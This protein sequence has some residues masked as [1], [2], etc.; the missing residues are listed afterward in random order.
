MI[1]MTFR[2]I[3]LFILLKYFILYII[4]MIKMIDYR[5][6]RVNEL[7]NAGDLFYYS[8]LILFLPMVSMILFSAPIYYSFKLKNIFSFSV[9]ILSI[10][11][12]EYFV[13]VYLTSDKH[14]DMNGIVNG[15]ISLLLFILFFYRHINS[16]FKQSVH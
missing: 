3:L 4:R 12:A 9:A 13:Y 10:L 2:N 5:F 14:I 7:K 16:V 11:T 8:W 15:G 1:K 6:L